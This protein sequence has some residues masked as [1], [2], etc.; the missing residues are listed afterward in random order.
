MTSEESPAPTP[1]RVGM[2]ITPDT[3]LDAEVWEYCPADVV[4]FVSR[5]QIPFTGREGPLEIDE[6]FAARETVK[7][8]V[9]ALVSLPNLPS[10][11][12]DIVVFNCTAASAQHGLAGEAALRRT[13]LEAGA[14]RAL[15]TSG[16]VVAALTAL[17]A[18]R[19]AV[20]TPY[21]AEQNRLMERFLTEAGFEF[22]PIP[23]T[24]V[25][26]LDGASD[27]Q[28]REIAA[29]AYREDA[30]VLF[31]SCA[32]LRTRH[33]V[34]DLSREYGIP[35]IASLQA[36]MWAALAQIGARLDAPE[37]ALHALPWP[38]RLPLLDAAIG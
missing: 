37:H 8:A 22:A 12:P 19:I 4:P 35:V 10:V 3:G 32:A 13:M 2:L 25:P 1:R 21:T 27:R 9:G 11:D 38:E 33:L 24:T 23:T 6:L 16:A 5:L 18:T 31:V 34:A 7:P 29:A 26:H 28:I 30:S 17:G 36:T 20:G 14:R 15:T